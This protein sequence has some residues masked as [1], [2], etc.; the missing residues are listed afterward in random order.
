M[1]CVMPINNCAPIL[2][3]ACIFST[4]FMMPPYGN[5]ADGMMGF[6]TR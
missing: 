5:F 4:K 2:D 6:L 1:K 3:R